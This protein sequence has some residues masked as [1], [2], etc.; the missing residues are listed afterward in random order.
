MRTIVPALM[1]VCL[2]AAE[3]AP[4]IPVTT[5]VLY[6]SG[7]GYFEH[8]GSVE[9]MAQTQL[10]FKTGQINDV[11]KSLVLQ[12]LDGGSIGTVVYPSQ[13]PLDKTLAS[14]Q[15]DLRGNPTLAQVLGQLR[16]AA[17]QVGWQSEKLAGTILGVEPRTR[18]LGDKQ[19][20]T[21]SVLNLLTASGLRQL[22]LDEVTALALS[23][24]KLQ[25][26][27]TSALAVVAQAR[28]QDSKPVELHFDGQ[29]K[30]GVRIG[31]V[32]ETPLWKVSYRLVMPEVGKDQAGLQGWA[33]VD[34]Q[35]DSD[36][37]GIKLSLVSGRPLSFI[38]DL[39][40]PRYLPRP[41]VEADDE[42]ALKPQA[43]GGAMPAMAAG[44]PMA[45]NAVRS[46][47]A[48]G[49]ESASLEDVAMDEGRDNFARPLDI[50]A[51]VRSRAQGEEVGALF[52]YQVAD[53][54]LPRQ[55]SAMLPIV[56]A[57]VQV[58]RL[59]IFNPAV[60]AK[61][62]LGGA[63][64]TNTTANHLLAGPVSVF[65]GG[66]YAGDAQLTQLPPGEHRLLSFALD[67]LVTVDPKVQR[68]ESRITSG[69][70]VDGVLWMNQAQVAIQ[71]YSFIDSSPQP[72][73]VLVEYP[74]RSGWTLQDTPAPF[75]STDSVH[76][77]K[78][79]VP[80]GGKPVSFTVRET[81]VEQ[82]SMV[83][84]DIDDATLLGY[85]QTA[86][87]APKVRAALQQAAQLKAQVV[88]AERTRAAKQAE[89]QTIVQDQQRL[90]ENMR[91]VQGNQTS[92]Y[93]QRL[94][95]K[96]NDQESKV[97]ALQIEVDRLQTEAEGKRKA[98]SEYLNKLA[99]E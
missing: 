46:A 77:F 8:Q 65:D 36:W 88:E 75:E 7:V 63:L 32:V 91:T 51:S 94:L 64:V 31:Y 25:S 61:H 2:M 72:R 74:R 12:D 57:A 73:T 43:Y 66:A 24:P 81:H 35:T 45:T 87:I 16:G 82:Q 23:D 62:P 39:Y 30:R 48:K 11:L 22:P 44:V 71:E 69:R 37:K 60:H 50:A 40:R 83:I 9:G 55:R 47:R 92:Q 96:L 27:L 14:F 3:P 1:S 42:I 68:E 38:Q 84:L 54:T 79:A 6:S 59:S 49:R 67:L 89:V 10:R 17:V 28:D 4:E 41:V 58:E 26:E 13:D 78:V 80:A 21:I 97:E 76:R 18:V 53:V 98:L 86:A 70:I 52:Q 33:M 95:T 5:V 90:R 20:V 56:T 15:V 29:G 85:A 99:I 34:N 19:T 93:Y